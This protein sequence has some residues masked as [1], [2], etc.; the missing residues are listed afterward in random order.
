MKIDFECVVKTAIDRNGIILWRA[1]Y[2]DGKK[3]T[4]NYDIDLNKVLKHYAPNNKWKEITIVENDI[5]FVL[6][7]HF[8]E[9]DD[10]SYLLDYSE[11]RIGKE[12]FLS[13]GKHIISDFWKDYRVSGKYDIWHWVEIDSKWFAAKMNVYMSGHDI[14]KF[15]VE[16]SD[17]IFIWEDWNYHQSY[18]YLNY[19]QYEH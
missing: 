12:V 6:D 16:N 10:F 3:E 13:D 1:I 14:I 9:K 2:V 15:K 11:I 4:E 8:P 18:L 7:E 17:E 5:Y 19:I